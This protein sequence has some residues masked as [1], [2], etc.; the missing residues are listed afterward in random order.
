MFTDW[1]A[2]LGIPVLSYADSAHRPTS[3]SSERALPAT[4]APRSCSTSEA[5][6]PAELLRLVLEA[7]ERYIDRAQPSRQLA[8]ERRQRRRLAEFLGC[9]GGSDG[10]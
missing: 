8:E 9:V 4:R 2:D 5:L 6:E 1:L 3:I 10:S 7:V